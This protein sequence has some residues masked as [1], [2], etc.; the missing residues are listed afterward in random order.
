MRDYFKTTFKDIVPAL[1][2]TDSLRA[3]GA[4]AAANAGMADRLFL[5]RG[6]WKSVSA[7]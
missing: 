2:S 5:R 7:F 4:S 1:F 6:R 3:G